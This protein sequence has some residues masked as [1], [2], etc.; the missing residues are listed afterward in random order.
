MYLKLARMLTCCN[1]CARRTL[2]RSSTIC[3]SCAGDSWEPIARYFLT[4]LSLCLH[5]HSLSLQRWQ[6]HTPQAFFLEVLQALRE[7]KIFHSAVWA[8]SLLHK[9]TRALQEFIPFTDRIARKMTNYI[10]SSLLHQ[11]LRQNCFLQICTSP[12]CTELAW[13]GVLS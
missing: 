2:Q 11:V 13:P 8:Y 7:Q 6:M 4:D 9:D 3:I 1:F 12:P 5:V 10:H